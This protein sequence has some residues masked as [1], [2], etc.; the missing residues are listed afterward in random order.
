MT[1]KAYSYIRFSTPQQAQ[2]D[3]LRRQIEAA[4]EWAKAR[5]MKLDNSLRDLGVSAYHGANSSTGALSSFLQ[6]VK[7]GRVERGSYLIVESLDR[8]SRETV[9]DAA[10]RL[11]EL[12]R[13]GIIVVTLSDGQ[14]YSEDSLRTD[15]TPLIISLVVMARAHEESLRKSERVGKVWRQKRAEARTERTPITSRCPEWLRVV[16]GRFVLLNERVSVVRRIFQECIDGFGRREIVRRLNDDAIPTF[17]GGKGWQ[18]SSVAKIIQSRAVI[19]EYQPHI[20]SHRNGNRKPDGDPVKDYYPRIIDDETYWRAQAAVASRKQNASGRKG[21]SGAHILQGLA[22]CASCSGPM[23]ILNK[24]APPKGGIYLACSNNI[25]KAGCDNNVRIRADYLE[26]DLL[27]AL[28][29]VDATALDSLEKVHPE[30]VRHAQVLKAKLADAKLRR[31]RLL[32]LVETG[33]DEAERRFSDVADEVKSL[34][35]ELNFHE[36]ELELK[37]SDPG[38]VARL[39]TATELSIELKSASVNERRE[40]R[41]RLSSILRELVDRVECRRIGPV[42]VLKPR[43]EVKMSGAMPFAFL[44]EEGIVSMLLVTS[45]GREALNEFFDGQMEFSEPE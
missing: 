17:R 28:L 16:N 12:M 2:G 41:V 18:T 9:I 35:E 32:K 4:E 5:N 43:M 1:K 21:Q 3:S 24:G 13:A 22:K 14:E 34:T 30:A 45:A 25:R 39:T 42:M 29:H 36:K 7:D 38:L 6:M 19:G 37:K 20:G 15:W 10:S 8:I 23:H 33:D 11:I 31:T 40:L 27:K 44:M 26:R